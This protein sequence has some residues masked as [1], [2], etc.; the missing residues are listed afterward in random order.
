MDGSIS[1]PFIDVPDPDD[2]RWSYLEHFGVGIKLS[3]KVFIQHL[4]TLQR[5]KVSVKRVAEIYN[6]IKAH[7]GNDI[8]VVRYVTAS[9][10]RFRMKLSML[11]FS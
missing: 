7:V 10:Q 5:Q 4:Q 9:K 1:I 11:I 6:Q 3:V 8:G 2:D